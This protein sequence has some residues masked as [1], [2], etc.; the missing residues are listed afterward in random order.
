MLKWIHKAFLNPHPLISSH[1]PSQMSISF[2]LSRL[3]F[4]QLTFF[5][6]I[7]LTSDP[8]LLI[9]R[10]SAQLGLL[11]SSIACKCVCVCVQASCVL[12]CCWCESHADYRSAHKCFTLHPCYESIAS[13][14]KSCQQYPCIHLCLLF[15]YKHVSLS[16]LVLLD[17]SVGYRGLSCPNAWPERN[18]AHSHCWNAFWETVFALDRALSL[19][20]LFERER[21][22]FA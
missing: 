18:R 3:C 13:G 22:S 17:L 9:S 7:F 8:L 21:E 16:C 10:A 5:P 2:N 4:L 15:F 14:F 6:L 20:S 12:D 11:E 1:S 19:F